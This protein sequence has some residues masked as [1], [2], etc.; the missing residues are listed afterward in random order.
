MSDYPR[1]VKSDT[2]LLFGESHQESASSN[3]MGYLRDARYIQAPLAPG[4]VARAIPGPRRRR[5]TRERGRRS[6]L[7]L[8]GAR[9]ASPGIGPRAGARERTVVA[10]YT[11]VHGDPA[12]AGLG[13]ARR[14]LTD[15]V[16][17]PHRMGL[18]QPG[19]TA[20]ASPTGRGA[21]PAQRG[22]AGGPNRPQTAAR[23]PALRESTVRPGLVLRTDSGGRPTG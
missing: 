7:H 10:G 8:T 13:V 4:T 1:E 19:L 11:A 12:G 20:E 16:G 9:H 5:P 21:S 15:P 6:C 17:T 23:V 3:C 14:G 18:D 2:L 22:M